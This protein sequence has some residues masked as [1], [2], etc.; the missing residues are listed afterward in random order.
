MQRVSV[1]VVD[2]DEFEENKLILQRK[3]D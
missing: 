2:E 3:L 1:E